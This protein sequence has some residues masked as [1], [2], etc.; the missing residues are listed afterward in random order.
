MSGWQHRLIRQAK[1]QME[2]LTLLDSMTLELD[3]LSRAKLRRTVT[4]IPLLMQ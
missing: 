3:S 2:R 4:L 1:G